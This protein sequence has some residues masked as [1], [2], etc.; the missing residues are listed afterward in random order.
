MKHNAATPPDVKTRYLLSM[1]LF[2]ILLFQAT[3]LFWAPLQAQLSSNLV[4][5]LSFEQDSLFDD[6]GYGN[7]IFHDGDTV[8]V[9]GTIGNALQFDGL[10][11][12]LTMLG[13]ISVNRIRS[14]DFSLSFYFR[15]S[16]GSGTY[17]ILSKRENCDEMR[18][19]AV[20]YTP[21]SGQLGVLLSENPGRQVKITHR[22]QPNRCWYHIAIIRRNTRVLLYVD[23]QFAQEGNTAQRINLQNNAQ[24]SIAASPCLGSGQTRF[25][26]ALDELRIYDRAITEADLDLLFVPRDRIL[27][28]DTV[29]YAGQVVPIRT[30]GSCATAFSWTPASFVSDPQAREPEIAPVDDGR[31]QIS[32]IQ[33]GCTAI[34]T[35][36]IEV[37]DPSELDCSQ[38]LLPDA[39]TP[40]GDNL[41][42]EFGI[43]NP[44]ALD[45]LDYFEIYD[46]WGTRIFA[47][48]DPFQRWDGNNKGQPAMPGV[49]MYKARYRCQG[50]DF[51]KIG[52]F[53]LIR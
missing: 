21:Q 18:A 50:N 1:T 37:V 43:S 32:F 7:T 9:C 25:R 10:Q 47:T 49:F 5:Y 35:L 11:N 39:F 19:L 53:S 40:N 6:S 29:I 13:D 52:S 26:G 2:R 46:R 3:V 51:E 30:S 45:G 36:Y 15:P 27:T 20:T 14:T 12:F 17:D 41:N 42:E 33:D 22:L 23:G 48:T 38:L 44:L 31:Y 28:R 8:F 16:G 4:G 24:L 34:D